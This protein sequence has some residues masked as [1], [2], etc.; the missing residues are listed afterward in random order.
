MALRGRVTFD[1]TKHD[2]LFS[3]GSGDA[4]FE[5]K[6]TQAGGDS[7]HIY[8]DPPSIDDGFVVVGEERAALADAT[9]NDNDMFRRSMAQVEAERDE[10]CA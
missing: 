9:V 3:I 8:K 1:Y 6:W 4:V 7:I 5:T 2:G 10:I